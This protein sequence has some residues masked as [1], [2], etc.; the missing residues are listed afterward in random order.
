M[1]TRCCVLFLLS[2][3][4][5]SC[6]E[7]LEENAVAVSAEPERRDSLPPVAEHNKQHASTVPLPVEESVQNKPVLDLS[8]P[9][10]LD[11]DVQNFGEE[12]SRYGV[13][14]WF[15]QPSQSEEQRLKIKTKLRMKEGA[16]FDR[17]SSFSSYGES[18]DGAEMGFEYKTR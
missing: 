15:D 11:G 13:Q 18:V 14:D 7:K 2:I 10:D 6:G 17:N 3:L 9:K 5:L 1:I 16:E 8:L 4:L 12:N